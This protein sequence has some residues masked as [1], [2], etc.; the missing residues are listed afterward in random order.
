MIGSFL[1]F[2]HLAATSMMVGVIW[3]IQLVHY[4]SFHYI[5]RNRYE[6]FQDFHMRN[7]SRIVFPLMSAELITG[8]LLIQSPI[9]GYSNKLFFISMILLALIW[10]LTATL[11][12]SIHKNLS[13]GFNKN[14]INKLVN[15]NWLRTILWSLRIVFIFA[16]I[17]DS[18]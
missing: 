18:L 12:I 1:F 14:I 6:L 7:I 3:V 17:F 15:L 5:D 8:I 13:K 11:F 10:F 2:S 16:F 9:F 4:P